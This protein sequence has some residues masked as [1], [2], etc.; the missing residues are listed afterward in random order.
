MTP[1]ISILITT[2]NRSTLLWRA[3]ASVLGQTFADL[4]MVIV[5]DCSTDD[6]ETVVKAMPDQRIRY[7]RLAENVGAQHGDVELLRRFVETCRGEFFLY[8]CDDDYLIPTDFLAR[9]IFG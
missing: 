4:E 6:T 5:D 3:A 7:T 8:L 9:A 1:R 2:F